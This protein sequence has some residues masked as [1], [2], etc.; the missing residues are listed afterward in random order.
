[1]NHDYAH[2]SDFKETCPMDCFRAQLVRD[3]RFNLRNRVSWIHFYGN[4]EC[5]LDKADD[6]TI[7]MEEG[8]DND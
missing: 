4:G 5:P 1:M 7:F 8:E 3:L 6:T 2:C